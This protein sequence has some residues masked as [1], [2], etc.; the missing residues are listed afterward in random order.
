MRVFFPSYAPRYYTNID[1]TIAGGSYALAGARP[2]FEATV[3]QKLREAGAII[4]GKTNMSEFGYSRTPK[5]PN[6]WSSLHGQCTGAFFAHQDPSGSSS[7]CGVAM[8]LGLAAATIGGEVCSCY[9]VVGGIG[10]IS[11]ICE[12]NR[13][14]EVSRTLRIEMV[15][16]GSNQR[17][18]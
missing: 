12:K 11:R 7:G 2:S 9:N 1:K 4:L 5:A 17:W 3:V 10:L 16:L 13:H 18:D 8:S 15:L 14:L 6:G